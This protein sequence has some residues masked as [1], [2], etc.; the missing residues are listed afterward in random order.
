MLF[1]SCY[2]W[3]DGSPDIFQGMHYGLGLGELTT[4]FTERFEEGD[5]TWDPTVDPYTLVTMFTAMNH[6]SEE[7]PSGYDFIGYDFTYGLYVEADPETCVEITDEAGE[8]AEVICGAFQVEE[9]DEAGSY[10]YKF[11]DY[12]EN[13][14]SRYAFI[15]GDAW[16][17]EDFPNLDLSIMGEGFEVGR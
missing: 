13:E 14:G 6:P 7:S 11:G 1:R 15:R 2:D 12:R 4:S 3:A 9:G 8:V 10:M 16:W 17:Y 5:E